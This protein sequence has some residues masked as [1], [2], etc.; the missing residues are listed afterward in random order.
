MHVEEIRKLFRRVSPGAYP[1]LA[2]YTREEIYD[3]KMGPGGLYL[4]TQMARRL[5]LSAGMRVLDMGCGNGATSV[6]LAKQYGVTVVA[7][8]L[9]VSATK[10][11]QRF[12]Q[13]EVDE[14]VVPLNL[15]VTGKIPFPNDYFDAIFCMDAIHYFGGTVAFW[16]HILPH[17]KP[18]GTLCIG[19]PC[20]SSEFSSECVSQLPYVY[21]DGT[22]LWPKE[23]SRYHS[24][25]WWKHLISQ[26]GMMDIRESEALND[27]I[28][29]WEDDVLFNL[30]RGGKTAVAKT[31]AA[32]ITFRQDGVPFLTHFVL[33]AERRIPRT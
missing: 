11:F 33:S 23:F 10:L 7:V 13:H 1:E 8:D 32:Q 25:N 21:E 27:G 6:F 31:D 16:H 12:R 9:W 4:A 28:I 19:S 14:R 26:T 30:E 2:G 22:D 29:Y 15:D 18:G 24:P 3:G 20:F 17:L 5:K